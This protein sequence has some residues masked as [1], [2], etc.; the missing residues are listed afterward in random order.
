[1]D[2]QELAVQVTSRTAICHHASRSPVN[3]PLPPSPGQGYRGTSIIRNSL[4]LGTYSRLKPRAV[5]WSSRGPRGLGVF[6]LSE[7][8]L[9]LEP[10]DS[11]G[12]NP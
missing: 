1:M 8:P 7:V 2:A 6:F 11:P 4:P 9:Y 3:P 10:R 5:R 12:R